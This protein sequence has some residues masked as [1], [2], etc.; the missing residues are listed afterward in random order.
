MAF[1]SLIRWLHSATAGNC[2]RKLDQY[3]S[4]SHVGGLID[5]P[6]NGLTPATGKGLQSMLDLDFVW[7]SFCR[8][9]NVFTTCSLTFLIRSSVFFWCYSINDSGSFLLFSIN[10]WSSSLLPL[11]LIDMV[12]LLPLFLVVSVILVLG[13][14][15]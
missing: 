5:L 1:S 4:P 2:L 15:F 12:L 7:I 10:T 3:V 6:A 11:F 14:I 13:L 9:L 8:S